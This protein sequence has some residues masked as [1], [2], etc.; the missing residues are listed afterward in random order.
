MRKY[1]LTFLT[2]L[3]LLALPLAAQVP[4]EEQP[5]PET[6]EEE[7][8]LEQEIEEGAA[9]VESEVEEAAEEVDD[10]FDT[11][12]EADDTIMDDDELPATASPLVALALLGLAGAGSALGVRVARRK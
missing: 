11:E 6:I 7:S 12:D 3:A 8:E 1:A 2:A 10:A 5:L 4:E 9:E